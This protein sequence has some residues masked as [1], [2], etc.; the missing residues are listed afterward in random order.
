MSHQIVIKNAG[1]EK[2]L[3]EI[4][5]TWQDLYPRTFKTYLTWMRKYRQILKDPSGTFVDK[6]GR[7]VTHRI[8]V[9]TVLWLFIQRHIPDFGRNI[10]DL[11]LLSKCWCDFAD[12]GRKKD[13]RKRTLIFNQG[14][15]VEKQ[16][17]QEKQ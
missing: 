10:D 6:K 4:I 1:R 12:I 3:L 17:K 16:K 14:K 8:Q 9:P 2:I 13:N 7:G 11:D 5:K 15:K